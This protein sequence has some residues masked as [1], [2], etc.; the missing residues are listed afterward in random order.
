METK[1]AFFSFGLALLLIGIWLLLIS[2]QGITGRVIQAGAFSLMQ[3]Y[4]ALCFIVA[5]LILLYFAAI[6]R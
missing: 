3:G 5:A 1:K 6:K 2:F 4:A